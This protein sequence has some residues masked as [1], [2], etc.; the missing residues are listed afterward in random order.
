M[1]ETE[2]GD[3]MKVLSTGAV[4]AL[5]AFFLFIAIQPGQAVATMNP[6][7][8][9]DTQKA[10][11]YRDSGKLPSAVIEFKNALQKNPN[12][13]EARLLL[14][15]TYLQMGKYPEAEKELRRARK[16][17]LDKSPVIIPLGEALLKQGKVSELFEQV[18][19]SDNFADSLKAEIYALRGEAFLAEGN[20]DKADSALKQSLKF[21]PKLNRALLVQVRLAM[22]NRNLDLARDK[23]EQVLSDKPDSVLGWSLSGDLQ[24]IRGDYTKAEEAYSKA[25][26][27][28]YEHSAVQLKRALVRIE[29]KDYAGAASDITALKK[30][31]VNNPGVNFAEGLLSFRQ[32][33]AAKAQAAFERVLNQQPRNMMAIFYLGVSNYALGNMA[34]AENYLQRFTSTRPKSIKASILLGL[35]RLQTGDFEGVEKVLRP[36]LAIRKNDPIVLNTLGKALVAQGKNKEGNEYLSKAV[37]LQPDSAS[38][39]V[40]LA[41]SLLNMGEDESGINELETAIELNPNLR[42]A[43]MLVIQTYLQNGEFDKALAASDRLAAKW[44][45]SSAPLTLKGMAYAGKEDLEKARIAFTQALKKQ[46]GEPSAAGNLAVLELSLGH[47]DKA[48]GYYQQV[49]EHYPDHLKTLLKLAQLES[50]LGNEVKARFWLDEAIKTNPDALQPR[51]MLARVELGK[52]KATNALA[53]LRQV[54]DKY[55]NNPAFIVLQ[56]E[57]Q[58]ADGQAASAVKTFQKLVNVRPNLAEAHYKLAFAYS[59]N[60]DQAG[61][62]EALFSGL[63]LQS[64]HPQAGRVMAL[65]VSSAANLEESAKRVAELA[66][67]EP[68][69]KRVLDL[70]A[71]LALKQSKPKEALAIYKDLQKRF[72]DEGALVLKLAQAQWLVGNRKGHFKTLSSWLKS[73][74]ND[75]AA[76]FMLANAYLQL[77]QNDDAKKAFTKVIELT[78]NNVV[79]LNNLAWLLRESDSEKALMYAEKA[80][81]LNPKDAGIMD[82]LGVILLEQGKTE[83]AVTVLQKAA[84]IRPDMLT[85]KY[86][87]ATAL[88]KHG[89]KETARNELSWILKD[90][91]DFPER[92]KAQ[93]LF[94][95]LSD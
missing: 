36:V 29:L 23:L 15:Q 46:P 87:L 75:V 73:H 21:K 33:D 69:H 40:D 54:E 83:R 92:E 52:G 10:K 43:D 24:Q 9:E 59:A 80:Q 30:L 25:M 76:Q 12:N 56:G 34:Q 5:Y 11:G 35:T 7:G 65:Y 41:I 82:T 55:K 70:K 78:P 45:D 81:Q 2:Q 44:P 1:R 3:F 57:S 31:I 48:R 64:N 4:S 89:K 62:K 20:L 49:I 88:V 77:E 74:P 67:V 79:A 37:S 6:P 84:S 8:W 95:D 50:Q 14:G 58:M 91:K 61:L 85:I 13:A 39:R 22:I 66:N 86:H 16:L 53:S 18:T 71:Q 28:S 42:Q 63:K 72:P 90:K 51:L 19:I 26:Q 27:Y 17:I 38:D 47:A 93:A 68:E 94:A 32:K 60:N